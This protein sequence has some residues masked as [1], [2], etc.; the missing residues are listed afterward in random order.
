GWP[1]RAEMTRLLLLVGFLWRRSGRVVCGQCRGWPGGRQRRSD[2]FTLLSGFRAHVHR[3]AVR[4]CS[5]GDDGRPDGTAL[6]A[7]PRPSDAHETVDSL[8]EHWRTVWDGANTGDESD[9]P[10]ETNGGGCTALAEEEQGCIGGVEA[11]GRDLGRHVLP[12]DRAFDRIHRQL[13]RI[14]EDHRQQVDPR[15][16]EL[17]DE[18][19]FVCGEAGGAQLSESRMLDGC[20]PVLGRRAQTRGRPLG[21]V[22]GGDRREPSLQFT[23]GLDVVP[24]QG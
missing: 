24:G 9:Q 18:S 14:G 5:G 23:L 10:Y 13:S 11:S 4:D 2:D 12:H 8:A 19:G 21:V 1:L 17:F 16:T 3:P 15:V 6:W 20:E 22:S 7:L